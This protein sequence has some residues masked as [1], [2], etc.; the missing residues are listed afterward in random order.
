MAL[1]A[2]LLAQEL[3]SF[4]EQFFKTVDEN[5]PKDQYIK[6]FSMII[7]KHFQQVQ[8]SGMD[9]N[10]KTVAGTLGLT[11]TPTPAAQAADLVAKIVKYWSSAIVP[12]IPTPPN[13]A[14]TVVVNTAATMTAT[15][16]AQLLALST[17]K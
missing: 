15:L 7:D 17:K 6:Q 10:I 2:N 4:Q 5:T 8:L 3:D 16:T 12:G 14:V 1:V 9:V 13:T 11:N